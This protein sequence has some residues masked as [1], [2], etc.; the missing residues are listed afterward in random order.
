[1]SKEVINTRKKAEEI[2]DLVAPDSKTYFFTTED[3]EVHTYGD[4]AVVTGLMKWRIRYQ[5]KD[6]DNAHRYTFV[7]VK[8]Q[9]QWQI[10]AQ[11][12]GRAPQK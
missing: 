6:V 10:V 5:E 12:I 4:A 9:G 3:V 1:M 2:K 11:H 7:Y 8:K